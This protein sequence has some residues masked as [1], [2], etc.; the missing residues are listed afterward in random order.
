MSRG[1]SEAGGQKETMWLNCQYRGA[2]SS[3]TAHTFS[4]TERSRRA[5]CSQ[6][7]CRLPPCSPSLGLTYLYRYIDI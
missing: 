5:G 3:A 1:G 2:R 4:Y 7:I 6:Q